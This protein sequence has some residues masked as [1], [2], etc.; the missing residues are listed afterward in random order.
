MSVTRVIQQ[1]LNRIETKLG[2]LDQH[3]H[4][5]MRNQ[6]TMSQVL[7]QLTAAVDANGA[8]TDSL[9][10]SV[11]IAVDYIKNHPTAGNDPELLALLGKV[12]ADN[13]KAL[14]AK[15]ALDQAVSAVSASGGAPNT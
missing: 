9:S 4:T 5:I 1:Q 3:L 10:D 15:D 7:D 2:V 8:A 12:E 11:A 13:T 14:A 6:Q